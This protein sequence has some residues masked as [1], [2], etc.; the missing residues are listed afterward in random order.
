[1]LV[2]LFIILFTTGLVAAAPAPGECV[3]G[4]YQCDYQRA[5]IQVCDH[6][7]WRTAAKC[8]NFSCRLDA[9]NQIPYCQI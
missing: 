6:N 5:S 9:S 4:D 3:V 2:K 1:M 7:G 8:N